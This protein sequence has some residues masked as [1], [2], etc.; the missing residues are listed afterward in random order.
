MMQEVQEPLLYN[1]QDLN[2]AHIDVSINRNLASPDRT[3]PS[4]GPKPMT[5]LRVCRNMCLLC[6]SIFMLFIG[7]MALSNLQSTMNSENGMGTESQAAI[8]IS[9]MVSALL[10][11]ELLVKNVGCKWTLVFAIGFSVPYI[12]ANLYPEFGT[13]LPTAVLLGLAAGP[14]TAAQ[15]I[16][17]NEMALRYHGDSATGSVD[18][19]VSRFFGFNSFASENTQIWGNLISYYVL[20]PN[21][22]PIVNTT[23]NL[24]ECGIHFV[25]NGNDT[26]SNLLPPSNGKRDMLVGVY[27]LCG[28]ISVIV[29]IFFL[30]PLENDIE[31]DISESKCK[32]VVRRLIAA[33]NQLRKREQILLIPISVFCGVETSFYASEFTKVCKIPSCILCLISKQ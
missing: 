7:F 1:T 6:F 12:A 24:S 22:I 18:N 31:Q 4:R 16:Y 20:R 33:L 26:N 21:M 2:N 25:N 13:L 17:V 14:L 3:M 11:P 9:S 28:I 27:L 32:S 23:T 30:D 10:L 5:R 19:V 29:M 15:S 8:Y